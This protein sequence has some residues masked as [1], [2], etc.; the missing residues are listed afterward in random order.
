LSRNS[1]VVLI[2]ILMIA[3][4][5][6]VL[7][8]VYKG[9]IQP[10]G[11]VPDNTPNTSNSPAATSSS[12][13]NST[14]TPAPIPTYTANI[15]VSDKTTGSVL[16]TLDWGSFIVNTS[17]MQY[18]NKTLT[19]TNVGNGT[20]YFNV[21][22]K[23][24]NY[25]GEGITAYL[26]IPTESNVIL[27]PG[28]SRDLT[29]QLWLYAGSGNITKAVTFRANFEVAAISTDNTAVYHVWVMN[30]YGSATKVASPV[31]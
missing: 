6:V 18:K 10:S 22:L 19:V 8:T 2:V 5:T 9:N 1:T 20:V 30:T 7:A 17:A 3:L 15:S 29:V 12:S 11:N 16:S 25:S 31:K 23:P 28:Q 26:I 27:S 24:V 14:T 4:P 13:S 21:Y